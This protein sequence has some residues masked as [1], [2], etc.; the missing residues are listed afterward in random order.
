LLLYY[1]DV[2]QQWEDASGLTLNYV[3]PTQH[4]DIDISFQ[5]ID[6]RMNILGRALYPPSGKIVFD[7]HENW[8]FSEGNKR[9]ANRGD[10]SISKIFIILLLLKFRLAFAYEV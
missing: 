2:L 6:D 4:A 9:V 8:D 7:S 3:E 5:P 1:F 10:Y